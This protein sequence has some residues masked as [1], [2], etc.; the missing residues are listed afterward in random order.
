MPSAFL[1]KKGWIAD[2]KP[3]AGT[4]ARRRVRV[5]E[6]ILAVGDAEAA[7]RAYASECERYC[8][9]IDHNPTDQPTILH[10]ASIGA[11][12]QADA[13]S[14][15]S[16][17]IPAPSS[18]TL[19]I[20]E[21]AEMHPATQHECNANDREYSRHLR[22]LREFLS[23][24]GITTVPELTL[25]IVQGWIAHLRAQG[26]TW[27]GR[28]HRLRMIRRAARIGGTQGYPDVLS[29]W[30]LD[31]A[32]APP[33]VEVWSLPELGQAI[34]GLLGSGQARELAAVGLGAFI[35]LRSSEIIRLQAGD[36]SCDLLHVAKRE[37]KNSAS[38][39]VLPL[40]E[41]LL[42][43]VRPLAGGD[44]HKP[45]LCPL[46]GHGRSKE[47]PFSAEDYAHWLAPKLELLTGIA[48][49]PKC[50]RKS[51]ASWAMDEG[52]PVRHIEAFLGHTSGQVA[53]VT[54]RHY[55]ARSAAQELRSSAQIIDRVLHDCL[56][57]R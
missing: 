41:T 11:I 33:T 3:I 53:A 5:P 26:Y 24:S 23:W 50:L 44:P 57:N 55:L 51:F 25:P 14:L 34:S 54:S 19:T 7:A 46:T 6:R 4:G 35:G 9:L 21:A 16:S 12:T 2:F 42:S 49:P 40:P 52:V 47:T 36:L 30:R 22:E 32:E 28:Q 27:S 17:G 13:D 31:R 48:L 38:R 8:R 29:G 43:W 18:R 45:L 1:D 56:H 39:R 10:A 15:L 37:A 20:L